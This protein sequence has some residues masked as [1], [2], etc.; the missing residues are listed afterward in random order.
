MKQVLESL[1]QSTF[2]TLIEQGVVPEGTT[3]RIQIERTRD[4]SH[5]DFASNLAMMLAKPAKKN[6]R[7]LAQLIVDNLPANTDIEKVEIAGP[8]FINFYMN[9][10]SQHAVIHQIIE[11]NKHLALAR[12][13]KV[14][15]YK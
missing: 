15:K 12:S 6:P 4:K 11:K 1:L 13:A 7:E 14:K 9:A 10:A 8:G 3:P 2:A 5:G